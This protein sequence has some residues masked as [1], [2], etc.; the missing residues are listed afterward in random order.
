MISVVIPLY[1][2]EA[3]ISKTLDSVLTQTFQDFEI[4]VIDD[5]ST[6]NSIDRAKAVI[7]PRIRIISQPNSGVSAARNRGINEAG[8][9]FIAFLDADDLWLPNYL[10]TQFKLTEDYPECDVFAVNYK[11][12]NSN[13]ED[14]ETI[15]RNIPFEGETGIL[16]NY[17][18]V[19]ATSN[20]P[21]WTGSVMIRT[22]ALLDVGGFPVGIR[23]G[24][25]LLTWAKLAIK[26]KIAYSKIPLAIFNQTS[27]SSNVESKA[28]KRF[29]EELFVLSQL[30]SLYN[31]LPDDISLKLDFK[32]FI[33][34]W[35]RISCILCIEAEQNHKI[36]PIAFEAIRFGAPIGQ[37]LIFMIFGIL[38]SRCAKS[39]F[40]KLRR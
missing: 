2:K 39:L 13:A 9:E 22:K 10:E 8:G 5:G 6:D 26:F 3:H 37:M 19:A 1:N 32:L 14:S 30:M 29:G 7:D 18:K 16:S 12:R 24:E 20:P 31:S 34:R 40:L 25:D 28:K 15:I 23:S 33:F 27:F 36:L 4:I 17:F 11:F 38:P 21:I 35:Q